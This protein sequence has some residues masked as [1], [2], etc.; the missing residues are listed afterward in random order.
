MSYCVH[1]GVELDTSEKC[2]PLCLTPVNDP[3]SPLKSTKPPYPSRTETVDK[4]IDRRFGIRL[5]SILLLIPMAVVLVCDLAVSGGVTWSLYV[6]GALLCLSCWVLLPLAYNAPRPYL[7]IQTD[8]SS[9]AL[10][11]LLISLITDGLR[12]YLPLALPMTL[13]A[14]ASATV[15]TLIIRRASL[16][17]LDKVAGILVTLAFL[18]I[19]FETAIDNYLGSV[20]NLNWSP[21]AFAALIATGLALHFVEKNANLKESIRKRLYI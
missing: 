17:G 19:G 20:V 12:W 1:C 13:M 7:Y 10:Y 9:I 16:I 2:C 15:I 8:I 14:G 11:L 21:Y 18:L 5:T 6:M 3:A 4:H